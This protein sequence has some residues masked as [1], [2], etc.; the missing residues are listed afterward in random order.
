MPISMSD[1]NELFHPLEVRAACLELR[2]GHRIV[3]LRARG[4][5]IRTP[6]Q[7]ILRCVVH[8]QDTRVEQV[9]EV[10]GF[11]PRLCANV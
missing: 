3:V 7:S 8:L 11:C 5:R 10:T 4:F 6:L 9:D 1:E 2:G